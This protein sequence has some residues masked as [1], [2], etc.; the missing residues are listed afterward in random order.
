MKKK[1]LLILFSL[2]LLF[3]LVGCTALDSN[4]NPITQSNIAVTVPFNWQGGI[5][6]LASA[7][8]SPSVGW[9][10]YN[11][12]D[13][14]SYWYDGTN[15]N[16]LCIG[17]AGTNGT[18][19]NVW[20]VG[21]LAPSGGSNGDMYYN[22]ST[23]HVWQKQ[24]GS[25]VDLGSI[26][27]PQGIQGIQG[28]QGVAGTNGTNGVGVPT[29]GTANQVLSKIDGT[30]YNTQWSSALSVTSVTATTLNAPTGRTATYVIAASNSSALD[31]SQADVTAPS[32]A[33]S[34]IQAAVTAGYTNIA[35]DVGTFVISDMIT[36]T[37]ANLVI[38]GQGEGYHG[39]GDTG[40]LTVISVTSNTNFTTHTPNGGIFPNGV[41]FNLSQPSNTGYIKIT[42]LKIVFTGTAQY[43]T[44]GFYANNINRFE[45]D[46]VTILSPFEGVYAYN[47]G[48][49]FFTNVW[50]RGA[51]NNCMNL[52]SVQD[53]QLWGCIFEAN[54]TAVSACFNYASHVQYHSCWF[55]GGT[56][57]LK[58]LTSGL[59]YTTVED[60]IIDSAQ[61][62]GIQLA[63]CE[64]VS[65][66]GCQIHENGNDTTIVA[67]WLA[68]QRAGIYIAGT[69]NRFLD[70][71]I[72][73]N[74]GGSA[75]QLWGIW[76][77]SGSDY[78]NIIGNSFEGNI[79]GAI[80]NRLETDGSAGLHNVIISNPGFNPV[81]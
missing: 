44:S 58:I 72:E 77:D 74:R 46:N 39:E 60:C 54:P 47:G 28:I 35:L 68:G 51:A 11:N 17:V 76:N 8:S 7:P 59:N 64:Y 32:D 55:S 69:N 70:N 3:T 50:I 63:S 78:N 34:T 48:G 73:D 2:V 49:K 20:T 29:G 6:G 45:M 9:A 30:D 38:T 16:Y 57:A 75:T 61:Q 80:Y 14:I 43:L 1:L 19:G 26:Q 15:W 5:T 27:G 65:I 18:N 62:D 56:N 22:S 53:S 52:Q 24:S 31:K 21:T 12:V 81:V 23:Y 40:G 67:P 66:I 42:N 71:A 25:W 79:T 13:N 36:S 4:G 37:S 41:I 33:T 10:Y